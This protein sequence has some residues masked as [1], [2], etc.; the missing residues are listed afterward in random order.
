MQTVLNT[1][2]SSYISKIINNANNRPKTLFN[3]VNKLVQAPAHN[4]CQQESGD[5]CCSFLHHF[6]GKLD[7]LR[8]T[9]GEEPT[10]STS[11]QAQS[12]QT[13]NNFTLTNPILISKMIQKSHSS[14]CRLDPAPTILLKH[15]TPVI[16]APISHLVNMTLLSA[17]VPVSLKTAAVTPILKKKQI[18]TQLTTLIIA[19]SP[20]YRI[21]LKNHGKGCCHSIVLY[22]NFYP[23]TIVLTYF[24]LVFANIIVLK[25]H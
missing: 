5:L 8:G 2:H 1:A 24:S 25:L 13:L 10:T 21:C 15:C 11:E 17:S 23:S 7:A 12:I 14:S 16:S 6:Q 19:Q 22:C 3:I 9:F 18:W 4:A 20:I